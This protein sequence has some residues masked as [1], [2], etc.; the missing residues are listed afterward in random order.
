MSRLP[1]RTRVPARRRIE[2]GNTMLFPRELREAI[3]DTPTCVGR[4]LEISSTSGKASNF[5]LFGPRVHLQFVVKETG[6]LTGRFAVLADLNVAEARALAVT[7]A[8]L[9][10]QA[11][12]LDPVDGAGLGDL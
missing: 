12:E 5:G 2:L 7:L 4:V 10:E 3:P 9:A 1:T 8:Q 6:K 11:A